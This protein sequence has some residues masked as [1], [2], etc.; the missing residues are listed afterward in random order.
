MDTRERVIQVIEDYYGTKPTGD[1]LSD[2]DFD[3]LDV[4]ELAM[5]LEEEFDIEIDDDEIPE[6]M[7][8]TGLV[9]LIDSKNP[10]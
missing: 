4:I 1:D 3:S 10:T 9:T 2:M 8:V 5:S 7:T 6:K